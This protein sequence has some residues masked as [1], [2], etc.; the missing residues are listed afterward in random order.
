MVFATSGSGFQVSANEGVAAVRFGTINPTYA[1]LFQTFSAQRLFAALDAT[2]LDVSFFVA[3][4]DTP[5][6]VS[7]FGAVFTN[8]R[9]PDT[10]TLEL[11]DAANA[12]LGVYAAPVSG[13]SGL[14]FVGVVFDDGTRVTRVRITSGT[15]ALGPDTLDD[16]YGAVNLVVMDDFLY[17]EPLALSPY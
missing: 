15:A 8:V 2:T 1:T 14:S 17:G 3:G 5:A 9:L 7:G 10:T 6:G 11:F 12:S 16:G 13:P 4:S